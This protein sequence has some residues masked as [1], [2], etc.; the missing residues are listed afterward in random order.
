MNRPATPDYFD[1]GVAGVVAGTAGLAA[2]VVPG[3]AGL[4]LFLT[5]FLTCGLAGVEA[6]AWVWAGVDFAGAVGAGVV[7][8]PDCA[9]AAAAVSSETKIRFFMLCLFLFSK[10]SGADSV[11]PS[12]THHAPHPAW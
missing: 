3:V 2:A 5:C 1:A 10:I 7:A 12:Q 6:G 8:A 9:R 11:P 4:L